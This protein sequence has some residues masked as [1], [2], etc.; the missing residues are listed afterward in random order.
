MRHR[1]IGALI[2]TLLVLASAV[3]ASANA[4]CAGNSDNLKTGSGVHQNSA[5]CK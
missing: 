2:A 4:P 3:S 5:A 1:L